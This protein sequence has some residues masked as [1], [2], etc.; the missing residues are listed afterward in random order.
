MTFWRLTKSGW[1]DLAVLLVLLAVVAGAFGAGMY[2]AW[3]Q[4][5]IHW[6]TP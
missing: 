5:I 2:C 6:R 3:H 4:S 1:H